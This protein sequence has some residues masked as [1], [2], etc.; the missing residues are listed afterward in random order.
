MRPAAMSCGPPLTG[1]SIAL[2]P[3]A[4]PAAAI[5]WAVRGLPV[6]WMTISDPSGMQSTRGAI[7][8]AAAEEEG[9]GEGCPGEVTRTDAAGDEATPEEAY[10]RTTSRTW[11]SLN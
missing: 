7:E 2:M 3:R 5:A 9:P 1:E 11:S 8:G 4:T 10:P 6:V